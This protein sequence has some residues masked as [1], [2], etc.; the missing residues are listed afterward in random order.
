M[1]PFL[2]N[3]LFESYEENEANAIFNSP[4]SGLAQ[5]RRPAKPL[6][7]PFRPGGL[8]GVVPA[9]RGLPQGIEVGTQPD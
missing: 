5:A 7:D 3:G 2:Q 4:L 6:T 8:I 1:N 9:G